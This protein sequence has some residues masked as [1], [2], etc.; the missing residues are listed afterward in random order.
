MNKCTLQELLK[1]GITDFRLSVQSDGIGGSTHIIIHALDKDSE[2]L[3]F[4]VWGNSLYLSPDP[5]WEDIAAGGGIDLNT[6]RPATHVKPISGIKTCGC[7]N[8]MIAR[9]GGPP[10]PCPECS[11][12]FRR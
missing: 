4:W 10:Y 8:G 3:D 9:F 2:T 11:P 12:K 1:T 6:I 7:V 5:V